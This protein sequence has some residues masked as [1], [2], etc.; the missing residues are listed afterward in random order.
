MGV[1]V[2]TTDRESCCFRSPKIE[3]LIGIRDVIVGRLQAQFPQ[4][5]PN[6]ESSILP[7]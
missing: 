5:F 2:V 1:S 3:E 7:K 6:R 4:S